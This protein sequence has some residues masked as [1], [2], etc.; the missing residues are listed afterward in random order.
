M[1]LKDRIQDAIR[2]IG[3]PKTGTHPVEGKVYL[4]ANAGSTV[5]NAATGTFSA[6]EMNNRYIQLTV[7]AG[8]ATETIPNG[9]PG[10][11]ITIGPGS[12]NLANVTID[13]TTQTGWASATM[14]NSGE[15]YITF[16]YLDDTAGWIFMGTSG[17]TDGFMVI[18][19]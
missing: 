19:V 6:E 9:T 1:G 16:M 18:S 12:A 11:M 15:D 10:Q 17:G 8:G 3:A 7:S 14:G 5:V 13:A 4:W 2:E